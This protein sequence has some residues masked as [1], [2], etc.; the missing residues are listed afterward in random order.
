VADDERRKRFWEWTWEDPDAKL[1]TSS[2]DVHRNRVLPCCHSD[3][4]SDRLGSALRVHID[5][6]RWQRVL[7]HFVKEGN[8]GCPILRDRQ[9]RHLCT[10]G[11]PNWTGLPPGCGQKIVHGAP[12][13]LAYPDEFVNAQRARSPLNVRDS[14]LAQPQGLG[15]IGLR[16]A[17][18]FPSLPDPSSDVS[19]DLKGT[20]RFAIFDYQ[21]AIPDIMVQS[22]R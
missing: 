12:E 1:P 14:S 6:G 4:S 13:R 10:K 18:L 22:I 5:P 8:D 21:P 3:S 15:K 11:D 9:L 2:L 7:F 19:R 17:L 20:A 16:Y